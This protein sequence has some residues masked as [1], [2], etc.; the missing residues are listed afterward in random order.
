[1]LQAVKTVVLINLPFYPSPQFVRG[2]Q[3]TRTS[4][5]RKQ[6]MRQTFFITQEVPLGHFVLQIICKA[7][8]ALHIILQLLLFFHVCGP[9]KVFIWRKRER[10]DLSIVLNIL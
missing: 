6:G 8:G 2:N 4:I 10:E 1:M 7:Q 5:W 3:P 9:L